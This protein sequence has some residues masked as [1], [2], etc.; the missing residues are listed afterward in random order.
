MQFSVAEWSGTEA[1]DASMSSRIEE[2]TVKAPVLCS[3]SSERAIEV[4]RKFGFCIVES[5]AC[6]LDP[7]S[8]ATRHDELHEFGEALGIV[9]KQSPRDEPVEVRR[10]NESTTNEL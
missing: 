6:G 1:W 2:A 10:L 4:I 7:A 3:S 5:E 8:V 9:L